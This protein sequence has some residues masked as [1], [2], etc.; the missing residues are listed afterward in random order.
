MGLGEEACKQLQSTE[1]ALPSLR[2]PE[3]WILQKTITEVSSSANSC[4]LLLLSFADL[5]FNTG[6]K[7]SSAL[8]LPR[9]AGL[10]R[11]PRRQL[12]PIPRTKSFSL[13]TAGSEL[14]SH[15]LAA[16]YPIFWHLLH[17]ISNH[18]TLHTNLTHLATLVC[19]TINRFLPA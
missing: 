14:G 19:W 2:C 9:T 8:P 5:S 13:M 12:K 3:M 10:L 17:I 1:Y 6:S 15:L 7:Y 18:I 11:A 16:S 4:R